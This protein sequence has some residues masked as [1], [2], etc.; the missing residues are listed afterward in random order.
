MSIQFGQESCEV[1]NC[2]VCDPMNHEVCEK[3]YDGYDLEAN[4]VS[5]TN[6]S[7]IIIL[8][9][10]IVLGS[11]CT[12]FIPICCVC[13]ILCLVASTKGNERDRRSSP[14][15]TEYRE[16]VQVRLNRRNPNDVLEIQTRPNANENIPQGVPFNNGNR[17]GGDSYIPPIIEIQRE[18]TH[19]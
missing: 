2:D 19:N 15:E 1:E 14:P 8:V 5:C 18:I 6:N 11:C 13:C 17:E 10:L 9:I 16:P 4:G 7:I 12:I 3:C